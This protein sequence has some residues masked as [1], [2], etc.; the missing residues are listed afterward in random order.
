MK[1]HEGALMFLVPLPPGHSARWL[2]VHCDPQADGCPYLVISDVELDDDGLVLG[3]FDGDDF[4][5]PV[6]GRSLA[7]PV[8]FKRFR[9]QHR[10]AKESFEH[11]PGAALELT[12]WRAFLAASL[13][14]TVSAAAYLP[15]YA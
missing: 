6:L 14:T 8:H 12:S 10:L 15:F 5:E 3:M 11:L 2:F 4:A 9:N 1:W 7:N 13:G